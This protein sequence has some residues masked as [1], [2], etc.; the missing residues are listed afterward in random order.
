[1][2]YKFGKASLARMEL[3]H[4][5]IR[6]V[7]LLAIQYS[8]VDYGVPHLCGART[9]AEQADC[10]RRGVSQTM[11]SYHLIRTVKRFQIHP[12]GDYALAVD[13][14]PWLQM[15]NGNFQFVWD[16][17]ACYKMAFAF[18]TAATE[19]GYAHLFTWGAAWDKR[20][21]EYG[22]REAAYKAEMEAYCRRHPGRDF[23]DGP[24][25]QLHLP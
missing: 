11:N 25:M 24:H 5:I 17:D 23:V 4:P 13:N 19:L 6:K 15:P 2:G 8:E 1:M 9:R 21:S 14:V 18:D 12:A 10:V 16:W 7:N 22:G 20:L 3:C